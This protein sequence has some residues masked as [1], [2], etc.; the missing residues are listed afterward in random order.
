MAVGNTRSH[1][2]TVLLGVL[3]GLLLV[4]YFGHQSSALHYDRE[5]ILDGE[6]YRLLTF[7][8]VHISNGHFLINVFTLVILWAMYGKVARAGEWIAVTF[9]CG[10][11]IGVGLLLLNPQVEW[12]AGLSGLLYALFAYGAVKS[13]LSREFLSSA[14]VVF[15]VCKIVMEQTVGPNAAM[16]QFVGGAILIDAHMYG[17]AS[18]LVLGLAFGWSAG[19]G[20][21]S[22]LMS[23]D[24]VPDGNQS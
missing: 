19:R 18:G 9:G 23:T 16:E 2:A 22:P 3:A 11:A 7:H 8:F 10:A 12:S 17:V 24:P 4:A 13:V 21:V 14:V 5:A 15:L 6:I 1:G 20:G